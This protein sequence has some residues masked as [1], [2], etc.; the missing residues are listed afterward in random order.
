MAGDKMNSKEFVNRW[1]EFENDWK[2]AVAWHGWVKILLN[3]SAVLYADRYKRDMVILGKHL[4]IF[5]FRGLEIG[6]AYLENIEV[7]M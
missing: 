5:Y 2:E 6:Q 1:Q 7:V 4:I 3:N